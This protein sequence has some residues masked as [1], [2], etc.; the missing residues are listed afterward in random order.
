[1]A[2]TD[3]TKPYR[4]WRGRS[5]FDRVE[6]KQFQLDGVNVYGSRGKHI[7]VN[8]DS[9]SDGYGVS[10]VAKPFAT[11]SRAFAVVN[12]GDTIHMRGKV[13][14][15][16]VTPVQV[17][18]VTIIGEGNRPRHADAAPVAT[19]GIAANTWTVPDS[20]TAATPCLKILQQ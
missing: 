4:N 14:E 13:K 17:F 12:S 2:A 1:M 18:D 10:T 7:Y 20:P 3:M 6:A 15:Q 11:M 19:G 9:G 8:P 5:S 16:L